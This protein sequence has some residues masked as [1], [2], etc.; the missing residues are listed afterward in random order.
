[1]HRADRSSLLLL[2]FLAR[3]LRDA[4]IIVLGGYRDIE[5]GR[6]HPLS[7]TLA[8]LAREELSQRITLQGLSEH[9]VAKFIE[10]T[11]GIEPPAGLVTTVY[12]ETE[13]NPFFVK[14]VVSLLA[15]E[16]RLE[17]GGS[18]ASWTVAIPE[19]VRAVVGRRLDRLSETCDRVL[20]I[21]SVIGREFSID[22]L[23]TVSGIDEDALLE[24]LEEA[25]AARVIMEVPQAIGSYR[26]AHG[27]IRETLYDAVT[28]I[29]RV[30]FHRQIGE[31]LEERYASRLEPHLAEL[32]YHFAEAAHGSGDV[33]KAVDYAR[34]AGEQAIKLYAYEDATGHYERAL[35]ALD[36]KEPP[37]QALRCDLLLDLGEAQN[38]AGDA[39]H[40]KE[41][42]LKGAQ[43]AR[44]I[45][46]PEKL[47]RAALGYVG[48]YV[49]IVEIGKVDQTLVTMLEE[50]LH[51]LNEEDSALR[52]RLMCR[53]A[54]ELYFFPGSE[55][56]R[57]A[58]SQEA[59]DMARRLGE[60]AALADALRARHMAVWSPDNL[61]ER[62][63]VADE[64]MKLAAEH[65]DP[66]VAVTGGMWRIA[67]LLELGEMEAAFAALDVFVDDAALMRRSD[68]IWNTLLDQAMR[69]I[70]EGR[71][72]DGERLAQEALAVGQGPY[73]Q[74]SLVAFG[75][76]IA[77][78]RR[79]QGRLG[80]L[81]ESVRAFAAQY[82]AI[83]GFSW[84]V[85]LLCS[86]T[87]RAS[88]AA[89]DFARLA[90][91]DFA[92]IPRD[93]LWLISIFL[94]AEVCANLGDASRAAI[95]YG[96]LFP[97]AHRNVTAYGIVCW[98]SA[99]QTLG[100]LAAILKR[101]NE[102]EEHFEAALAWN[103]KIRAAP[104]L[105]RTQL[106]YAEMLLARH[107]AGDREKAVALLS[108]ALE[109]AQKLGMAALTDRI[110]ALE[111]QGV[112]GPRT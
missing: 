21:A 2:Q 19:S 28:A 46:S 92:D 66:G 36:L 83:A 104:W 41:T 58:L 14:E 15:S 95:L 9:N 26:F 5:L 20:T 6:Q 59:V 22:V 87:G 29:R 102:A 90:A 100:R 84:A 64:L 105:V 86:E 112:D 57:E 44:E 17:P 65:R 82:P 48:T 33:E 10:M 52:A 70:L 34:R 91:S 24:A 74:T 80:E 27:L 107:G 16:R 35:Q 47:A 109:T 94:A 53:L 63:A 56:R 40:A 71:F 110:H 50:A 93:A 97:Y 99:E 81:E 7:H 77:V 73:P 108:Q 3:E 78:I 25:L 13:G 18:A 45:N 1:L 11:A 69:A 98:G 88:E 72:E 4:R 37:D 32:A 85:P 76:Q 96:L 31:A 43:L 67:D 60:P 79:D 106:Y 51:G 39:V 68:Q 30:R 89:A 103:R 55:S 101:W 75:L 12:K 111:L 61:E 54:M 62:L 49:G 8:E 23:A 42:L 38:A